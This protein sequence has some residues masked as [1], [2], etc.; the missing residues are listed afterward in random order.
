MNIYWGTCSWKYDSW[1]GIVYNSS[2]PKNY[3]KE[4]S[5]FFN[6]VEIDQ[7]FWSLHGIDKVTLPR[8]EDVS[9]YYK[10]VPDDFRFTIKAPNSLTLTHFY[11]KSKSDEL[12]KNP[13]FLSPD[14]FAE[15]INKISA[16]NS[17][18][19]IVMFQFE[20]LSKEK[21]SSLQEFIERFELFHNKIKSEIKLGIEIRNPNFLNK[22]FFQFL[23]A[24][25]LSPVLLQ[26]YYMPPIWETLKV[27]KGVISQPVIIRLHGP[28]RKEIEM[29]TNNVWNQII[30]PKDDELKKISEIIY[31]LQTLNVDVYVNV[32]NH[33]EG[34]APKTIEK[35]KQIFLKLD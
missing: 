27:M 6:S 23:S 18:I 16:M 1:E 14:L 17:K 24:N 21:M 33:Y 30:S 28:E 32:N 35:L 22:K 19:G 5:R 25:N 9:E 34:C 10:S 7:W 26:G 20:Y 11:R 4:Y 12:I 3:L 31:Y 2:K 15:F 8:E 29:K 13:Y